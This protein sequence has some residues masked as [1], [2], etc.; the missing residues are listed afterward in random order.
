MANDMDND[1]E[2]FLSSGGSITHLSYA[3]EK[4]V[5]KAQRHFYHMDRAMNDDKRSIAY[6]EK[7]AKKESMMIFS[8]VERNMELK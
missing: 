1:V 5:K 3:S 4:S 6:L 8:R 2:K 7:E